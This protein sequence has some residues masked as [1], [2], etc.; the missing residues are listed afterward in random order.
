MFFLFRYYKTNLFSNFVEDKY[1]RIKSTIF[2]FVFPL[3]FLFCYNPIRISGILFIVNPI[4]VCRARLFVHRYHPNLIAKN[5]QCPSSS[6]FACRKI[7]RSQRKEQRLARL[8]DFLYSDAISSAG[9][10]TV[11]N[12][13]LQPKT[14]SKTKQKLSNPKAEKSDY[15]YLKEA[16]EPGAE[17]IGLFFA[18]RFEGRANSSVTTLSDRS[19][20]GKKKKKY[21][22]LIDTPVRKMYHL[23]LEKLVEKMF[24]L[25]K[26]LLS[27]SCKVGRGVHYGRESG[28]DGGVQYRPG[29]IRRAR[30]KPENAR[31]GRRRNCW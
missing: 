11:P 19:S 21:R 14:N 2:N 24:L 22:Q 9:T 23:W 6:S 30:R 7:S 12:S 26:K 27:L 25:G 10:I 31:C 5:F 20:V 15:I 18:L 16:S 28:V 17:R 13:P 8:W 1:W 29:S 3:S 4:S